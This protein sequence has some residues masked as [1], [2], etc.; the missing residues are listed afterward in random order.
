MD[1]QMETL[2]VGESGLS[3]GGDDILCPSS[4][5][6]YVS[7]P[8]ILFLSLTPTLSLFWL[9]LLTFFPQFPPHLL[10]PSSQTQMHP[11]TLTYKYKHTAYT[12]C[13]KSHYLF[14][15]GLH[16]VL[17]PVTQ[18]LCSNMFTLGGSLGEHSLA[19]RC[20]WF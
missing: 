7:P 6:C 9:S 10:T 11:A 20:F 4:S 12:H 8:V 15:G 2:R 16:H 18:G 17:L 1:G 19:R 5:V 3:G 13:S 14:A